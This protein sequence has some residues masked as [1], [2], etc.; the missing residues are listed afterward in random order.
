MCVCVCVSVSVSV[1]VCV[2]VCV[3]VCVCMHALSTV[4][5]Q[6]AIRETDVMGGDRGQLFCCQSDLQL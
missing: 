4:K 5:C 1:C 3:S 2:C 6:N